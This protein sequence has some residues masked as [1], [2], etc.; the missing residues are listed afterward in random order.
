[1]LLA[2]L[3]LFPAASRAMVIN[4]IM[5]YPLDKIGNDG[6]WAE[7]Y[8][9]ASQTVDIITGSAGWRVYDGD[10]SATTW[11][12]LNPPTQGSLSISPGGFLVL[13]ADPSMFLSDH[14]GFTGTVMRTTLLLANA[15]DTIA[16]YGPESSDHELID[17]V[18][19]ESSWGA[20]HNGKTL[21]RKANGSWAESL[22]DGGTPG[23]P[24]S[25]L[26]ELVPSPSPEP[27]S[28]PLPTDTPTPTPSPTG[29]PTP[30]TIP[31]QNASS[32]PAPTQKPS[33]APTSKPSPTPTP[34]CSGVASVH[35]NEF[36]PNSAVSD[37]T[38]EW[39][40]LYNGASSEADISGCKLDDAEGGSKPYSI[41]IGSVIA[42][43]SFLVFWRPVTGIALNNDS[44]SVR[45]LL[46]SGQVIES[47]SYEKSPSGVSSNRRSDGSF[48]WSWTPTPGR[49]NV[50]T[51]EKPASFSAAPSPA[52]TTPQASVLSD[53]SGTQEVVPPL[54]DSNTKVYE[55]K[56]G[57]SYSKTASIERNND[58]TALNESE[59]ATSSVSSVQP[60]MVPQDK[61]TA[62]AIDSL[63]Q[64]NRSFMA[65]HAFLLVMLGALCG[66]AALVGW[67]RKL[68][69]DAQLVR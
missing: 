10:G 40:E 16:I 64:D 58:A 41:P 62:A 34:S 24:N 30:T 47:I 48:V 4:E 60:V 18:T 31:G 2:V 49:A 53:D 35:I 42:P 6:E 33:P 68:Q 56:T 22:A 66:A 44:D 36:L 63:S 11:H 17:S 51:P 9:D 29:T 12:I 46:P 27:S 37:E 55:A 54:A 14:P 8:N 13:T 21:E 43:N 38:G 50:I 65:R 5:Y 61:L 28:T 26:S 20:N 15:S 1:M 69:R 45:L 25:I 19:Y 59:E 7:L 23:A 39:I 3:L 57:Y 67:R 32:T 52:S